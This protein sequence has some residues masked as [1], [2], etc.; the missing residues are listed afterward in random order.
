MARILS[1]ALNPAIDVSSE[2]D[3]VR[4]THK[5]RTSNETYDPGGGGV[6]VA[7]AITELRGDVELLYLAGGVT[8]AFLDD[9]LERGRIPRRRIPIA[10]DTRISF[11]VFER[12]TGQE[13]RFVGG[14][15]AIRADELEACLAGVRAAQFGYLIASGSLPRGVPSDFLAKVAAIVQAKG[16][17]FVLDSSG[18]GL[19]TTLDQASVFLVK[20]SLEELEDLVGHKL[21][22]KAATEA[23]LDLVGRSRA[24]IVAVT[25][26]EAGAIVAS[27]EGVLRLPALQVEVRS[28]VGAGDSFLSAMTL[29]LSEGKS[30]E[31]ATLFGLAAGAAA[32]IRP[33]TKLCGRDTV[34][35]LYAEARRKRAPEPHLR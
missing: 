21:D 24:E 16:G 33:G 19:R 23:A 11:T 18:P 26:S 1:L 3:V 29:A 34:L 5:V 6:N 14:G 13:Y 17:R 9:L 25:M 31:E 22:E 10:G 28:S 27:R 15:P 12:K 20:P 35:E 8:G 4:I 2:A 7:R 30:I 32:L